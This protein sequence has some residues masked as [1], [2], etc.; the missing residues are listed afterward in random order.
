M[1][2]LDAPD[3]RM[4][5]LSKIKT[6]IYGGEPFPVER[7]KEAISVFGDIFLQLYGQTEAPMIITVMKKEDFKHEKL[8]KSVGRP[9]TMVKVR[10][11][12]ENNTEVP[13][14]E[15]GEVIVK[16]DH[17]MTGYLHQPE[18]TKE[19][20]VDGWLHTKDLGMMDEDGYLYLSG[21]RT[22][23][24]ILSGGENIYPQEVEQILYQHPSVSE[25]CAFG[26]SDEQWGET[27]AAAVA[28][29]PGKKATEEELILFC[30][31]RLASYKKPQKVFFLEELPKSGA[32]KIVR[33]ELKRMFA[34]KE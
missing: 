19:T 2:L 33:K 10:V 5:D 7:I 13:Q 6:I 26:L 25:A 28:L 4:K 31:E 12:N 22:S 8:L 20:I 18:I 1:R 34:E 30:K 16:G 11:V 27:V 32:G 14:G 24:M 15:I 21:G 9:A 3:I 17:L 29:K 23:D